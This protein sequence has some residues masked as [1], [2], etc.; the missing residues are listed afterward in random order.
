MDESEIKV[1]NKWS[2]EGI[3]VSDPGLV[4]YITLKP[5]IVPKTGARYASN[6]FHKSKIFIVE[7]LINKLMISGHKS[8]KHLI[9]SGRNTGKAIST[10]QLVEKA[11]T[12]IEKKLNKNPIEVFVKA[13]ENAAPR[14][15]IITI[16][17]GGARYPKA[18]EVAPQRR[19]DQA[20]KYMVQGVY[21]KSFDN[22]K[23]AVTNLVEEITNAYSKSTNSAAVAKKYEMERQSDS[24][25]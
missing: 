13:L 15:E 6:R 1:F 24:S 8:G 14:E 19:I 16:E 23:S 25:R 2:V 10:Y 21:Q 9:S 20:L 7:R 4:N 18:V 3:K 22:K 11:F 12:I 17:Y 5:R